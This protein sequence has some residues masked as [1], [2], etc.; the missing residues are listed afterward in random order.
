MALVNAEIGTV[1]QKPKY[2]KTNLIPK[3]YPGPGMQNRMLM[4]NT[5]LMHRCEV[6]FHKLLAQAPCLPLRKRFF[7]NLIPARRLQNGD[8]VAAFVA[9]DVFRQS[10]PACQQVEQFEVDLVYFV[11]QVFQIF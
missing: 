6:F 10:H 9:P 2:L 7:Q 4:R 3:P 5:L 1:G 8:V 11:P